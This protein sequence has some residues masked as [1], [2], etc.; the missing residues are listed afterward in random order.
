VIG[1]L[2]IPARP[3]TERFDPELFHHVL[4]VLFRRPIRS[5]RL[6]SRR[7][8]TN[9]DGYNSERDNPG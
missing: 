5:P 2:F 6:L 7:H 9:D 8:L 3:G 1:V 4:M